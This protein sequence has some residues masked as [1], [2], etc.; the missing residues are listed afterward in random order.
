MIVATAG[1]VDHGKTRL[2]HALTGTDTDR[3]PDEQRRGMTIEAGFAHADLGV[4]GEP[5]GFVDVPG[6]ERFIRNM[7]AGVA[8][9][10][11]ALVVV[12]ADDGPMPQTREHVAV[13]DLLG[14]AHGLVV[15]TKTDRVDAARVERVAAEAAALVAGT[16]LAGAPMLRVSTLTGDGIAALRERLAQLQRRLPLR[17]AQGRF[18]L[19]VDR[20]FTRA[21]AGLV[22]TGAVL[23]GTARV[24]DALVVSPAGAPLRLRGIQR[25]GAASAEAR[26][27]Q[28]CALNLAAAGGERAAVERGDWIV[29][30]A[31]HAPTQRLDVE[32]RLLADLP[33]ALAAGTLLH[34]HLGAA[35]RGARVTPLTVRRLEPG[36]RGVAQL[37]L[38]APVAALHGDRFVL[39]DP[40]A[41]RI[42]GGGRVVDPFAPARGRAR[43]ERLADLDALASGDAAD[44]AVRLLRAHPEGLDWPGFVLARN[45][46][47]AAADAVVAALP[48]VQRVAHGG[49]LR[50]VDAAHW[51]ALRERLDAALAAW[52]AAHADSLGLG[53][54]A[55]LAAAG[56]TRADAPLARAA[57]RQRIDA[58]AVVRDGFVLRL[59]HH[60]ARLADEDAARLA[61]LRRVLAPYGLRPPA[62]GE[63]APLLAL[64]LPTT[65]AFVHRA[66]QLGHLVQIAKNRVFLPETIEGLVQAARDTAAAAPDG[67]FDAASF[68]DRSGIGRNLSIQVLEFFDRAG[69]TRFTGGRR[70]MALGGERS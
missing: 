30:P 49:E 34:L 4:A 27:G 8:A 43:P 26:A 52:H 57:L 5:V 3:L 25:H 2:V 19:A 14:V 41:Q 58:G 48:P 32:L 22:V 20:V 12:A 61:Q 10:D 55:L 29:A 46:D 66:A 11:A 37:A 39:R 64:D 42:V 51:Q 18:R 15:V 23:S 45:L 69:I 62:V 28:R 31:A 40:A 7:L 47:D 16:S 38:D 65:A 63:I 60:E 59:A 13:L 24:G 17:A 9:V 35:T 21:G 54:A 36:A 50:L 6:H 33:K 68:R 67:R 70:T 56:V 53:E 1:H 44:A